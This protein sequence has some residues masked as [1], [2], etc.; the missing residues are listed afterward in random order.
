[1]KTFDLVKVSQN[2]KYR[3]ML[4]FHRKRK[5]C[6]LVPFRLGDVAVLCGV[7]HSTQHNTA[8]RLAGLFI[9]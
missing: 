6:G 3:G 9:E 8:I 4:P 1:M 2:T 5:K 7:L